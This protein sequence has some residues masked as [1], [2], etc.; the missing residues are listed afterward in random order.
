MT[1]SVSSLLREVFSNA[2]TRLKQLEHHP[3]RTAW[4]RILQSLQRMGSLEL[5]RLDA[6]ILAATLEDLEQGFAAFQNYAHQRKIT[7]FGSARLGPESPEYRQAQLFAYCISQRGFMVMTGG[8]SGIMEAGNRGAGLEN[9]FGLNIQLP[10]EQMANPVIAASDRIINFKYFFSRKLF[11]VKETDAL[12]LFPGGFGTQDEA[13][14]CLTLMQTGKTKLMPLV[15]VDRTG[16]CYW[17]EWDEYV[18]EHLLGRGLIS[19]EDLFLYTL[20]DDVGDA[21]Q[22]IVDFYRVFHSNRYVR[23]L[24]VLR[25]N[26]R[27][28]PE[29]LDILNEEFADILDSGRI[30]QTGALPEEAE[31]DIAHLPR[32]VMHFNQRNFGR[33]W[34]MVRRINKLHPEQPDPLQMRPEQK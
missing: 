24:L 33:L 14:E 26:T 29:A 3:N 4:L 10:F 1:D 19:P 11:F 23:E 16:G 25:L 8:G 22:Q 32:L 9:S 12:V 34:Q 18:R 27:L 5:S 15:L 13:F 17:K 20:T 31:E 6:K 28:S 21:C 30:E 7:V 2:E